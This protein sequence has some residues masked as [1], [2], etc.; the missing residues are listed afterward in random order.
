MRGTLSNILFAVFL[1]FPSL[2]STEEDRFFWSAEFVSKPNNF[3]HG[4]PTQ[5]PAIEGDELNIECKV[6]AVSEDTYTIIWDY[7]D[8]NA[9]TSGETVLVNNTAGD[10]YAVDTIKVNITNPAIIDDKDIICSWENGQFSDT[11]SLQFKVYIE[12]KSGTC[13]QCKGAGHVKLVRPGKQKKEDANLEEMIREKAKKTYG[14]SQV[15][16]D[17]DGSFCGCKEN[18]TTP[19]TTTSP[20]LNSTAPTRRGG[21]I[22]PSS[23]PTSGRRECRGIGRWGSRMAMES[24]CNNNCKVPAVCKKGYCSCSP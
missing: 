12:D 22:F 11:I 14:L 9:V 18:Q 10:E 6:R 3:Y 16:I 23:R 15:L 20:L 1:F 24:W 7:E 19:A 8:F 17:S 13:P 4:A 2:S 5:I 21:F